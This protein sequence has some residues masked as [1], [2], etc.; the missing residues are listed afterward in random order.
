MKGDAVTTKENH[1]LGLPLTISTRKVEPITS[2][3]TVSDEALVLAKSRSEEGSREPE[4]LMLK[5][6]K[7]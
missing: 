4:D 5:S 7:E 6:H 3:A 1:V 2:K